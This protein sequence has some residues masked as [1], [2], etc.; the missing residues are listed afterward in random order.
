MTFKDQKQGV[1]DTVSQYPGIQ[2]IES[3]TA[4]QYQTFL[5]DDFGAAAQLVGEY[6]F[7]FSKLPPVIQPDGLSLKPYRQFLPMHTSNVQDIRVCFKLHPKASQY[8]HTSSPT[9]PAVYGWIQWNSPQYQFMEP[10]TPPNFLI[11]LA[12]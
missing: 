6:Y 3:A 10:L 5:S 11:S 1:L 12:T 7:L 8:G 4:A 9:I 2:A